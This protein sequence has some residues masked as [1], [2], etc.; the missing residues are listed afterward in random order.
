ME[1]GQLTEILQNQYLEAALIFLLF[2]VIAKTVAIVL[3]KYLKKIT[4]KTRQLYEAYNISRAKKQIEEFFWKDFCDN[5]L[6]IVKKRI[7][8]SKKG[9]ESA[10]Y[11]L[12]K[13]LLTILKLISP[14]MPFITE[15]I[16]LTYFQNQEKDKSIHLSEWPKSEG[17]ENKPEMILDLFYEILAKIRQ[18]KSNAKK[19]MNSEVNITLP[20]KEKETIA[21]M[22]EDLKDV[23]N[24][25][26]INEGDFT[27]KFIES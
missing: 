5:Y 7:Y 6:E 13:S 24:A 23:I 22:L 12:Y 26:E 9:K 20:K 10:Q 27:I 25:K 18:E 19:A 21:E 11:V 16:Y 3:R 8:Q 1:L 14:I 2:V 4:E 15:E 17:G